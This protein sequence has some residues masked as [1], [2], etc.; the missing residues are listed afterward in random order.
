MSTKPGVTSRPLASI[1]SAPLPG[2]L[3]DGGDLAVLDRDIGLARAGARAVGHR[4]AADDQI[5]VRHGFTPGFGWSLPQLVL[6]DAPRVDIVQRKDHERRQ[7]QNGRRPGR[8]GVEVRHNPFV[9]PQDGGENRHADN[10]IDRAQGHEEQ[11]QEAQ[12]QPDAVLSATQKAPNPIT[13][14]LAHCSSST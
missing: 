12:E 8:R 13:T 4:A 5:E 9:E 6:H 1:S 14:K 2:D 7:R 10:E 11:D 3:A